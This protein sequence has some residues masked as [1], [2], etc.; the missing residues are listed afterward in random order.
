MTLIARYLP[1][2]P[3]ELDA[4]GF[5]MPDGVAEP[6][7]NRVP[8][9]GVLTRLNEPSTR[10]PNGSDG[11]RVFISTQVAEEALPSLVGMGVNV[12]T[13][14][15]DHDKRLKVGIITNAHIEGNDLVV[16]GHLFEKDFEQEVDYIKSHKS[17]LGMSYEISGV[18][19]EDTA[20]PVWK[21]NRLVFTGGA[22]LKKNAAAYQ[23][24]SIAASLYQF[25]S[26]D[27]LFAVPEVCQA[28]SDYVSTL[29]C[30]ILAYQKGRQHAHR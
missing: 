10:P 13:G 5:D 22:I 11:H 17:Q 2:A 3:F 12:D 1:K 16:D 24:T 28:L 25:E 19:V 26:A 29:T 27:D 6:H 4:I 23:N 8:F 9:S 18:D 7:V 30:A 21:L 14:F 15:K 20:A